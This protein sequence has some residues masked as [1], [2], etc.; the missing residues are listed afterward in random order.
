[1]HEFN[2]TLFKRSLLASAVAGALNTPL[3]QAQEESFALEEILVTAS[4]R[5]RSL[6]DT[7][8]SV[9]VTSQLAIEQSKIIDIADLQVLVPSLRVTSFTRVGSAVYAIRGFGNGG[10]SAGTEPAV[11]VFIDGVFRS[12]SS[13]S[14]GDLPRVSRIEVLSGPQSTLFGKNASAG[15]VSVITTPPSQEF[16]A[17]VEGTLGNYN[18]RIVKGYVSGAVTDKLSMSFSGGMNQRDG[19]TESLSPGLKDLN[20][21]DR[22][23]LRAQALF[24][25]NDSVSLR[26]IADYS[27]L[28][29]ICCTV[30]AVVNG[31]TADAIKAL[32]GDVIST[33]D[34]FGYTSVLNLDPTNTIED[35]GIS[36][37]A[38]IDFDNFT[39]TSIS[40]IRNNESGPDL[41]ECDYTS[42]DIC[43]GT[44]H[45]EIETFSQEL[46]LTSNTDNALS[47][48]VGA[49]YFNED[50]TGE[51]ETIYG[52][53][54]RNYVLA[55]TGGPF[56]PLP[57]LEAIAGIP[58]EAFTAGWIVGGMIEQNNEAYSVFG[59]FDYQLTDSLTA[60][61]GLNYTNDE[62][63]VELIQ[64]S[65]P[66]VFSALDLDVVAGGAFAPFK[67]L[68]FRPPQLSIPNAVEDGK[69]DDSDTT[70]LARLS[71]EM[72]DNFNFYATAST[73]F[74]SSSWDLSN[75]AHPNINDAAAIA[76]AGIAT[77]NQQYGNRFSS[78]EYATVY[79]IGMKSRF[80]NGS[81]N[82]AIF[83]QSIE[84]FQARTFDGVNFI[85]SNA[86]ELASQGVE[87]DILYAP[88][89]DWTFT[90]AGTY[91][92]PVYEDYR[93]APPPIG[94][95]GAIDRSGERPGGIHTL[96]MTG[97]V[98]YNLTF[99]N[100]ID[101]YIRAE[102]QYERSSDLS[103]SFPG[104]S[105]QV[106]TANASAGLNF[107]NGFGAQLWI[108]N[109][110]DDE[111]YTG[112]F[113]GVAQSGTVNSFLNQPQ[114]Y[115]VTVSYTF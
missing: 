30:G 114:T 109:L 24:E 16:E 56:S 38:D 92:D 61:L 86:G 33:D 65:N 55:L 77:P 112:A 20:D 83:D 87:F 110:N 42:L 10:S 5:E 35:K 8:I 11:G 96:S 48:M 80:D 50:I 28:D 75:F 68:Q 13:S 94:Q 32:G 18:Q 41:G 89:A 2:T 102:Y 70:W 90:L 60:T 12:R 104:L 14:I 105:R 31:P 47:W 59:T 74:K 4:K 57:T 62:K 115:G 15:V 36:F 3:V 44:S 19:F 72:N 6:Q 91:L 101:G 71:W 34:Q 53:D 69:T 43:K 107:N 63:E 67:G 106:N 27:D 113:A 17:K 29:E 93:N 45:R 98:V 100:G 64:T 7:P 84:D 46:R 9:S 108:R 54:L 97:S 66:D 81:L 25:P 22:Y 111:Y 37:H 40:A 95:S 103:D 78:P 21:K 99:D 52:D 26:V 49:S 58:G 73:G 88:T 1:M 76:A 79:E 39:L 23:N 51:A 82:I 85:S